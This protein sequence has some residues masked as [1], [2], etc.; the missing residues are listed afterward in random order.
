MDDFQPYARSVADPEADGLPAVSDADS[1][2]DEELDRV[3]VADGQ[4]NVSLPADRDDGPLVLDSLRDSVWDVPLDL[5]RESLHD[6]PLDLVGDTLS[7]GGDPL[8][9]RLLQEQ[10]DVSPE[11]VVTDPGPRLADEAVDA[12]SVDQVRAYAETLTAGDLVDAHRASEVSVFDLPIDGVPSLRPVGRIVSPS[13]GAL[14]VGDSDYV[15]YDAGVSG[16]GFTAEEAAM[17]TID[18][19]DLAEYGDDDALDPEVLAAAHERSP[20]Y[21]TG[22]EQEWDPADLAVAEG[23]DPTPGNIE[24]ARQKLQRLGRAAIERTVP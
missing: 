21:R 11:A 10:P 12:V 4:D 1:H 2:A 22:A 15:G 19:D 16:G 23:H 6:V 17:H 20:V 14:E 5:M 3:R 24:R 9:R 18:E 8:R 7:D 13:G